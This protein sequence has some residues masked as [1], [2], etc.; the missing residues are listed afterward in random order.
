V[1]AMPANTQ[2][3]RAGI[4]GAT[5]RIAETDH[6]PL[7][8]LAGPGTGKTFALMRRILR[9]VQTGVAPGRI[10]V[11]T[12][13]RTAAKDLENELKKLGT[14]GVEDVRADTLHAL[15]FSILNQASVLAITGRTPRPLMEFETRFLL[16]DL[17]DDV[18]GG[19]RACGKR[20]QAFNAAWARLQSDEPGWL[21]EDIDRQF[22]N[23]LL[24][25]LRFHNAM[26][27][28]ELI[29]ETLN[30]LRNNPTCPERAQFD[31][32]LV[33]E[34]QDL[35]RA[36]QVL[37][38]LLAANGK[39][40]VIGDENQS[41][42]TFKLAHPE[43]IVE[44]DTYHQG[45]LDENLTKCRRCPHKVVSM[46]NALILN[47][48]SSSRRQLD[49]YP[50]NPSGEV[51][52][53]QW[54]DMNQEAQGIAKFIATRVANNSV[55]A[56]NI[57]VLAPR[58]Q[59]G[60]AIRDALQQL[61]VPA[62]SFFNEEELD[63]NPK[64]LSEC[65]AQ[66]K[67]TLLCLL[68]NPEDRVALRCWCGFGSD[69]LRQVPWAK[70]TERCSTTGQSPRELLARIESGAEKL[71]HSNQLVERFRLLNEQLAALNNLKGQALLD[72]LYPVG[73]GWAEPFRTIAS[74][75]EEPDYD[76]KFFVQRLRSAI[77]QPELPTDVDYVRVMSLHKSKGLTADLVVVTG[78]LEGLIPN[79]D[80][81]LPAVEQGRALEEQR[82]LFYVAITRC[83][84]TL[85]LSSV[86]FLP[87][88]LAHRMRARVGR[89]GNAK[90]AR[91][92]AT[93]FFGQL[94][95][96]RP[97]PVSGQAFLATTIQPPS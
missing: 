47:S 1:Q 61:S 14:V 22:N 9:L 54:H 64:K 89:G 92:I 27:I 11:S 84:Q 10:L 63:G 8:V 80:R 46:A 26:L 52:I 19:I 28:G 74:S 7:R 29:P 78:C 51:H 81:D 77:V 76:A 67:F 3:W 48:T 59:F 57:L 36:E 18:F 38:D 66:E 12:F 16:Q 94:G 40:A 49:P 83:R 55:T 50:G 4:E 70:L 65:L 2:D 35:N 97:A 62:H 69:S 20:L 24:R 73:T 25:W 60:Y 41:I 21:T 23:A 6:S 93:S 95:R 31:H 15:C 53:V 75:I 88:D 37:L 42:Y 85:V 45:T 87:R 68:A 86:I 90:L 44:F 72:A 79:V 5:L 17:S 39:L 96:E 33:D 43:G 32:V 71:P 82:R 58:R 91:T 30:Y 56:G 13:T 34:Y